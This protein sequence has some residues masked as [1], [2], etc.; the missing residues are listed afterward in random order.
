MVV[1][2]CRF[3][4]WIQF[5]WRWLS[6]QSWL[7]N[8]LDYDAHYSRNWY[9]SIY[10][11][12]GYERKRLCSAQSLR[13]H[14]LRCPVPSHDIPRNNHF[15]KRCIKWRKVTSAIPTT[16]WY[17]VIYRSITEPW[18]K[19]SP[20]ASKPQTCKPATTTTKIWSTSVEESR[21]SG[22]AQRRQREGDRHN[23]Q[24][25]QNHW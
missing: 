7:A 23:F 4:I 9:G 25:I 21:R 3:K 13:I 10:F 19:I 20:T 16:G 24:F 22:E 5:I 18:V 17:E 2:N 1:K 11:A 8:Q 12:I 15:R 6:R 14:K